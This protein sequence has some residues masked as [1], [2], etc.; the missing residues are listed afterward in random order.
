MKKT[1]LFIVLAA[2]CLFFRA[3]GQTTSKPPGQI[4][5]GKVTD[6]QGIPLPGATVKLKGSPIAVNTVVDGTYTIGPVSA[7]DI[8][9]I[10]FVGYQQIEIRLSELQKQQFITRLKNNTGVLDEVQI[11]AYGTTTKR[12]STGDVSS[13]KAADIEKQPVSNPLAALEGRVPGLSITQSSGVSGA[14]F[15]VQIRGQS[16]LLQGSEPFYIIDGVPF[17]TGN[18]ALNQISSAAGSSSNGTGMSPF[19]LINPADIESIEVLKDADATAIYGSRGANGVILI[20]TKKGKPGSVKVNLNTYSG[21]SKVSR[22]MD[23]LNTQQYLQM[24][25]EGFKNSGL[26]PTTTNAP[27]LLLWDTTRYTD[28]KKLLIG[29]TAHTTDAPAFLIRR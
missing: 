24:R 4:I 20:T 14:G 29:G 28:F 26:T 7:N 22:T 8:F 19:Q 6:E 18:S 21:V 17:V 27:D 16:S 9:V 2:L 11:I 23:M 25:R 3:A 5:T 1:I 13:V 15:K 10:S 12:L